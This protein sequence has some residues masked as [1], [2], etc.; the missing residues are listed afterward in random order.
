LCEIEDSCGSVWVDLHNG[1]PLA[2]VDLV[3]DE[4]DRW[5]FGDE[6]EA[7][8]PRRLVKRNDLLF[9][10]IRGCD[11]TRIIDI[12]W[13]DWH[14]REEPVSFDDFSDGL[15]EDGAHENEY[16]TEAFWVKFSHPVRQDTLRP[17][18]FAMTVMSFEREG[19][20]Q[21]F[22]VPIV[23]VDTQNT[24][25]FPSQLNDPAGHV[26]GATMVVDG[27]W[28]DEAVRSQRSLFLGSEARVEIEVRGDLIVDCNGQT[29][30]ANAVGL[31]PVPTGNGTPGGT[32]LSTFR[33]ASPEPQ[34]R[35]VPDDKSRR[36][37][38]FSS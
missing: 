17:D 38:G 22:R 30:D 2:C 21:T 27:G 10:L 37:K 3:R 26:R 6:V 5:T 13:K 8:G 34:A 16:I 29:V 36:Q 31:S 35:A 28:V 18:C 19:W 24:T 11:L 4:C 25:N 33:V 15:G 7:C 14:R 20:W 1:V 9:D 23:G 32:F 12:G